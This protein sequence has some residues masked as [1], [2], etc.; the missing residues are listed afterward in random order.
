[1]KLRKIGILVFVGVLAVLPTVLPAARVRSKLLTEGWR[2]KETPGH[3]KVYEDPKRPGARK[4]VVFTT[5]SRGHT[6]IV[7]ENKA[8]EE[9][10]G[11]RGL[12]EYG[13][14]VVWGTITTYR[15]RNYL[16][17]TRAPER[18]ALAGEEVE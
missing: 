3:M 15:N 1:V 12:D 18:V 6:F 2:L 13:E 5:S 10:E 7:L 9:L 8:L 11:D 4:R 14:V 16:L 17:M